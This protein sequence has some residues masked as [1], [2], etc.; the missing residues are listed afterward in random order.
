MFGFDWVCFWAT[1]SSCLDGNYS[2]VWANHSD[3]SEVTFMQ[4]D[5]FLDGKFYHTR[6]CLQTLFAIDQSVNN[7]SAF[8]ISSN[9]TVPKDL[10]FMSLDFI[11]WLMG[12]MQ[13]NDTALGDCLRTMNEGTPSN[14][15]TDGLSVWHTISSVCWWSGFVSI[16]CAFGVW[17]FAHKKLS[18]RTE[19]SDA[20]ISDET[21]EYNV[22]PS[23]TR[24]QCVCCPPYFVFFLFFILQLAT[25]V[26][27]CF[28]SDIRAYFLIYVPIF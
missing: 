8:N 19:Q 15:T 22:K 14:S 2:S 24:C 23:C 27:S 6:E 26:V 25:T 7:A 10:S 17:I 28:L 12:G 3:D 4:A 13:N 11:F 16:L 1:G 20:L 18:N 5:T 21:D 9:S